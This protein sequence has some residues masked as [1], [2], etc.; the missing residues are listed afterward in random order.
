MRL[1]TSYGSIIK[2]SGKRRRPFAVRI[3]TGWTDEGK[4]IYKYIDYFPTRK[5]ALSCL[6][7]YNKKPYDLNNR[8][9]TFSELFSKWSEWKYTSHDNDVPKSYRSAYKWCQPLYDRIWIDLRA[10]EIQNV[11]NTCPK[12][13]S[14][15]K[16]IRIF[17]GLLYQYAQRIEISVT[18]YA[19]MTDLPTP[20]LSRM[21]RPFTPNEIDTLWQHTDLDGV[22]LALIYI[23]TG[24]RPTELLR[25]KT[26]NIHLTERYLRAGMKTAAGK[27][28]IIPIA[29]KIMPFISEM[30][31]SKNEY[32]LIDKKD[33][34]P[35]LTYDRLREHYWEHNPVLKKMN[36]LPHDCRHTCA[37]LLSNAEINKKVIQL[38][39]GHSSKDI[40]DKVY[41]HKTV[42]QLIDA[43]NLL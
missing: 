8:H 26:A 20:T 28:R 31:D 10:D 4:Q 22:R 37:T 42:Q 13:Y 35:V 33:G 34:K 43:V 16:N 21:H 24:L 14:T 41:T 25:T 17:I 6:D 40:T 29:N 19:K 23:Y 38:I 15:K 11:I 3:T 36:H 1:P 7:E 39:L 9:I 2:L 5:A 18:N 12:G 32:L 30:F 27:N